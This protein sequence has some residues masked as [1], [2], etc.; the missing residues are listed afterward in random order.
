[1]W[2]CMHDTIIIRLD[3][4]LLLNITSSNVT[5]VPSNTLF[6]V[7]QFAPQLAYNFAESPTINPLTFNVPPASCWKPLLSA[8]N[9]VQP[10][11]G[12]GSSSHT[13]GRIASPP[14]PGYDRDF[15]V[16]PRHAMQYVVSLRLHF[17][18]SDTAST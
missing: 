14:N 8:P 9:E 11:G 7:G 4:V 1:M 12:S 2:M 16:L 10:C 15:V 13:I 3:S 17:S 18:Q 6:V 5:R